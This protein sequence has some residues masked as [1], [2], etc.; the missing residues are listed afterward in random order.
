MNFGYSILAATFY[1]F[2]KLGDQSTHFECPKT[3]L[4]G[5]GAQ[6][7][8]KGGPGES[9]EDPKEAQGVPKRSPRG[10]Q[11]LYCF[12]ICLICSTTKWHQI[13][14]RTIINLKELVLLCNG[15]VMN[16]VIS[17]MGGDVHDHRMSRMKW[18]F[19]LLPGFSS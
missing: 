16:N 9:Q 15:A 18:L 12:C 10:A 13:L 2:A 4:E 5:A 6:R 19:I 14:A 17:N 3:H 7:V 1:I 8:P 11:N